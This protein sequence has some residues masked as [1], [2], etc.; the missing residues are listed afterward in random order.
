[1]SRALT[2]SGTDRERLEDVLAALAREGVAVWFDLRGS[3]GV[4]EDRY[5]DYI[6]AARLA[7]TDRWVGE[8]VGSV[9]AGGGFWGDDGRLYAGRRHGLHTPYRELWWSFN[10]E[11]PDLAQLLTRLFTLHGFHVCWSGDPYECV[12]VFLDGA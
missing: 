6:D 10:H 8:H 9:D 7:G 3:T 11:H 5:H 2:V 12:I 4:R 1:M